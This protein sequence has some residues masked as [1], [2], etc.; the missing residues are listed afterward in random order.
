MAVAPEL[1]TR[2][3][4]PLLPAGRG[5]ISSLLVEHLRRPPH[6][7]P[8]SGAIRVADDPLADDDLQLA[9]YVCYEL[10]YRG[11]EGVFDQWEWEPS[12]LRF[13]TMLE[14]PFEDALV[15]VAGSANRPVSGGV[16]D[17]IREVIARDDGPSL[18][19]HM[20][21]HGTFAAMREF[22]VHR[23]AY[24]LKEADP[25]T[26]GLPRVNGAA[27]AA[28]AEIQLD[29]YGTGR[30]QDRHSTRFAAT[31]RALELD[32]AY[33]AYLDR[34][35]GTT[36]ATINLISMLGLHR[37]WRGALVGHL[38]T[39]EMTSVEPMTRYAAALERLGVGEH[40]RAFY[41]VHVVADAVHDHVACRMVDALAEEEPALAP[42]ILFG[43]RC[44]LEVERRFAERLLSSW[45]RG[46]SSLLPG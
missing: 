7:V 40:G 2:H 15:A 39:F 3:Q 45:E 21:D 18:S 26:W 24:Q 35:P 8:A 22:A 33:G 17:A 6:R 11:F 20:Q 9:L 29:E 31:L 44:V 28:M 1:L 27:Q 5:P 19:R 13:R 14:Q 25:H 38:A 30:A 36:L 37:R 32:D 4:R 41:D 23:S 46:R 34:L 42:Q 16:C 43:A 12:L 10:H